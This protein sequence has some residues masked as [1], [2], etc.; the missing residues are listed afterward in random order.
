MVDETVTLDKGPL[1]QFNYA[2]EPRLR[3]LGLSTKLEKGVIVLEK[4]HV[5]CSEGDTLT[6]DQAMLLV[7]GDL[8]HCAV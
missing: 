3:D 5:V 2:L 4:D 1:N 6:A 8:G 7:S